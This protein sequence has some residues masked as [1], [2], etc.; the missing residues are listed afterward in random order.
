MVR[1]R[2]SII[3]IPNS[4]DFFQTQVSGLDALKPGFSFCNFEE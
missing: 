3:G 2:M 1:N 4:D